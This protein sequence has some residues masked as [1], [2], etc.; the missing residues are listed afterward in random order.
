[1]LKRNKLVSVLLVALCWFASAQQ[2]STQT[3][4]GSTYS[5]FNI[6][7]LRPGANASG[8]GRAGIEVAVPSPL[9]LNSINPAGWSDMRYVTLQ[10]GFAFEQYKV[11]DGS[12][13]LYQNNGRLQDFSVAFPYSDRYGGTIGFSIRPYS[14]VAYRTQL[15]QQVPTDTGNTDATLTYTG[16]GGISEAMLGTSF[17]PIERLAIG[18]TVSYYFG[19]IISQTGVDFPNAGLNPAVYRNEDLYHGVGARIGATVQPVDEL[20]LG[21]ALETGSTLKRERNMVSSYI[22]QGRAVEDT[23]AVTTTDVKVP[24]RISAGASYKTGRFLLS[25]EGTLQSWNDA[26]FPD[27]RNSLRVAAGVDRLASESLNATGFERW[28]FR[29]GG[30]YDQ[31]YYS[32][33]GNGINRMGV[34]LG[35]GIPVTSF[36]GMNANTAID[37]AIE[38]GTRGRTDGGLTQEMFGRFSIELGVSE[39]WFV[40]ARK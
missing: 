8:A 35:A 26:S 20:R 28:T 39:L 38:L 33:N 6:G 24:P 30:F 3:S 18:A 36:S 12:A 5:I 11:S 32:V 31:T 27:A 25:T 37:L 40:R 13:S 10:A 16:K 7:D 9:T 23:T 2:A 14:N 34:T 21:V 19:S 15:H 29:F 4:G 17:R 1:M 22:D